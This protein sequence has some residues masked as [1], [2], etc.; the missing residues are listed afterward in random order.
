MVFCRTLIIA[1]FLFFSLTIPMVR[2]NDRPFQK[3]INGIAQSYKDS[4]DIIQG[5]KEIKGQ[6]ASKLL[7]DNDVLSYVYIMRTHYQSSP[8]HNTCPIPSRE[9]IFSHI[10]NLFLVQKKQI[11]HD[12]LL[13][14]IILYYILYPQDHIHCMKQDNLTSRN[15]CILY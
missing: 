4:P 5:L 11:N 1:L 8:Q 7:E 2:Q 12:L 9:N 13:K 6:G 15:F 3:A 14:S 10:E